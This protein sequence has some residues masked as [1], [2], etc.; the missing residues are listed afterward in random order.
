LPYT[1]SYYA[2]T[3]DEVWYMASRAAGYGGSPALETEF[4]K[5]G[6]NGRTDEALAGMAPWGKLILP[7]SA[8]A[9]LITPNTDF[10]HFQNSSGWYIRR[11]Q[12]HVAEVAN[13]GQ[14]SSC[15]WSVDAAFNSSTIG[16][17]V[18]A[19]P[20]I[21]AA[22]SPDDIDLLALGSSKVHDVSRTIGCHG[23]VGA[24]MPGTT[25]PY[26][27]QQQQPPP[28]P[29]P[30]SDRA[31]TNTG[32][33]IFMNAS[34]EVAPDGAPGIVRAVRLSYSANGG[35]TNT[36]DSVGCVQNLF[37]QPL[38]LTLNRPLSATVFGD[39]SA[40]VLDV[41]LC[42]SGG[43]TCVHYF[44]AVNHT[45][46]RVVAL[47]M[48]ETR[49]LFSQMQLCAVN[50][51]M[52]CIT[53]MR[54]FTWAAV[55]EVNLLVT[56]AQRANVFVGRVIAHRERPANLTAATTFVT[57]G[58]QRLSL[59]M[60]LRAKPCPPI[61]LGVPAC[62]MGEGCADYLECTVLSD[63]T[64]CRAFDATNHR[65]SD[66]SPTAA[67]AD[68]VATRTAAEDGGVLVVSVG[69]DAA[70]A[71]RAEVTIIE[72][73]TELLGPFASRPTKT[74][75]EPPPTLP[76]PRFRPTPDAP[77]ARATLREGDK[78][79]FPRGPLLP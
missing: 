46:W 16:V 71:P 32:V 37:K 20:G 14:P 34:V 54:G 35:P 67:V 59:P 2:T 36:S 60:T 38:D 24:V 62:A 13:L 40:A 52:I 50:G 75:D 29:P 11:V 74:D 10:E 53:A 72:R 18:R 55:A 57:V 42:A 9:L 22:G 30:I 28:P 4:D 6:A 78:A 44:V 56:A 31:S 1:Q 45:G 61:A 8:K 25:P 79:T 33:S 77:H 64:S 65:L 51:D 73:S 63:A 27:Q 48:P 76:P 49:R 3:P 5:L 12:Y 69:A 7:D 41:Q 68:T 39:G 66:A 70:D 23:H 15:N 43:T 17:R 26:G 19:L 58:T 21:V 47:P